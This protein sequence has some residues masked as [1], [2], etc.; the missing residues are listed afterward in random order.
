MAFYY[1]LKLRVTVNIDKISDRIVLLNLRAIF[2]LPSCVAK[3]MPHPKT[4][5]FYNYMNNALPNILTHNMLLGAGSF[6]AMIG[7][8]KARHTF[9]SEPNKKGQL[10]DQF[11]LI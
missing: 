2:T 10:I 5:S 9:S 3:Q 4:E 6:N 7:S 11:N 8:I 1:L